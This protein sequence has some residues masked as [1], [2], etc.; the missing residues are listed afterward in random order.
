MSS[1]LLLLLASPS[2]AQITTSAWYFASDTPLP[3]LLG[4]IINISNNRTTIAADH[5]ET[6]TFGGLTYATFTVTAYAHLFDSGPRDSPYREEITE[7]LACSRTRTADDAV[8]TLA[9][10]CGRYAASVTT[11]TTVTMTPKQKSAEPTVVADE[12][13]MDYRSPGREFCGETGGVRESAFVG[14]MT[15]SQGEESLLG[16]VSLVLTAGLE[17]LEAEGSAAAA[18]TTT[19]TVSGGA[20]SVSG[21]GS[22]DAR[23]TSRSAG[24]A[25]PRSTAAAAPAITAAPVLLGIGAATVAFII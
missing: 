5:G 24:A 21:R 20:Q 22:A 8:A 10:D 18:T 1:L 6:M 25:Q 13:T 16:M 19:K 12:I 2:L 23:Q 14:T 15:L 7:R 9:E 17:K 3:P 4:S 11:T